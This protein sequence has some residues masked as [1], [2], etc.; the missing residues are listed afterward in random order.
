MIAQSPNT[1]AIV[2]VVSDQTDAAVPGAQVSIVSLETGAARHLVSGAD[3]S[4]TVVLVKLVA[5]G[6]ASEV[7]VYGTAQGVRN[8]AELGTWLDARAIE[9]TPLPGRKLSY[10]PL[11]NGA[12]RPAK[13]TAR[14]SF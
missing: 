13:G 8:D 4:V 7:T 1:A 2:V 9:E 14:F 11:L 6:G 12:F 3:G 10:L 5:T